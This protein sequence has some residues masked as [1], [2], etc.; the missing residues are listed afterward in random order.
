MVL[1]ISGTYCSGKSELARYFVDR[2]G[3]SEID[4][5]AVGHDAL[6]RQAKNVIRTFGRSVTA[7]DGSIDRRALGRIVFADAARLDDL[8]AIVH[9]EM[10]KVVSERIPADPEMRTVINAALLVHM[11]LDTLCNAVVHVDAP[12]LV[13]AVRARRRDALPWRDI[14]LRIERQRS[15]KFRSDS[16][17]T[18]TV[19][20]TFGRRALYRHADRLSR[21]LGLRS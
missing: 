17:D 3:F 21:S 20:N 19:R 11:G 16:V 10:V 5:D 14:K 8:E 7:G 1:G 18:Y 13:R 9:P 2:F 15:L 12:L 6:T 4:V